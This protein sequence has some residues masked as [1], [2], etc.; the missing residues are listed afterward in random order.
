MYLYEHLD[1]SILTSSSNNSNK[2]IFYK[3]LAIQIIQITDRIIHES[4]LL[5]FTNITS[6]DFLSSNQS[7]HN[8]TFLQSLTYPKKWIEKYPGDH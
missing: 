2:F 6:S 3:F 1:C 8:V 5:P 7:S 4:Y